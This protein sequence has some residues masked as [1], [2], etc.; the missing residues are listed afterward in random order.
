MF[1]TLKQPSSAVKARSDIAARIPPY[2]PLEYAM[3]AEGFQEYCIYC[4]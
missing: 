3:I 1:D 2:C 4:M